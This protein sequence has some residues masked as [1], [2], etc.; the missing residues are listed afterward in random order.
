MFLINFAGKLTLFLRRIKDKIVSLYQL[1]QIPHGKNC[2]I[3][4]GSSRFEGNITFGNDVTI[5]VN[6]TILS[7]DAKV[8]I[9]NKVLFGPHVFVITGNHQINRIGEY[10]T[11]IQ[12]KTEVCDEDIVIEDDVWIGAGAIILKGVTIGRG[13]VIGAGSVVTKSTAP[14]SINAGNPCKCIKMRFTEEEIKEHERLLK[15]K[16]Q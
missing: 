10:I 16:V 1:S 7:T 9:G 12:E 11:D 8:T 14:Y 2:S 13:S 3:R 15:N 5:G 4:G 6:S